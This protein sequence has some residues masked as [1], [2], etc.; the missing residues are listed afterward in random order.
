MYC[1][2]VSFSAMKEMV[3]IVNQFSR[4]MM[5]ISQTLIRSAT[6]YQQLHLFNSQS[7]TFLGSLSPAVQV[8][9][10]CQIFPWCVL[11]SALK[12]LDTPCVNKNMMYRMHM[13]ASW[14][15]SGCNPG[16]VWNLDSSDCVASHTETRHAQSVPL[17]RREDSRVSNAGGMVGAHMLSSQ[18]GTRSREQSVLKV[19]KVHALMGDV[20]EIKHLTDAWY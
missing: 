1:R 2:M 12:H 17:P 8:C 13:P 14:S 6:K 18:D 7:T 3:S 16:M 5:K 10:M 4:N 9:T 15:T 11:S 20:H 19:E